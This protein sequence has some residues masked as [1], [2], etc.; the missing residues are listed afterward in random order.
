MFRK[1]AALAA[2][3]LIPALTGCGS[4]QSSQPAK[5]VTVTATPSSPKITPAVE[6]GGSTESPTP[7]SDG[8]EYG[9]FA[10]GQTSAMV[11]AVQVTVAAGEKSPLASGDYEKTAE[12]AAQYVTITVTIKNQRRTALSVSDIDAVDTVQGGSGFCDTVDWMDLA[13]VPAGGS[14]TLTAKCEA[15]KAGKFTVSITTQTRDD[16]YGLWSNE[17]AQYRQMS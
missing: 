4:T 5:T 16:F 12:M 9:M 6:G 7:G 15:D 10:F 2:L 17:D 3:A 1:V 11:Q 14:K 8:M 13:A